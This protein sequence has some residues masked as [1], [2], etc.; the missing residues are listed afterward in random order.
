MTHS[1]KNLI[2]LS[3]FLGTFVWAQTPAPQQPEDPN[4]A[5]RTGEG[6][7]RIAASLDSPSRAESMRFRDLVA[8][9]KLKPGDSVADIGTGT[10]LLVP[11][12]SQAVGAA[13]RVYA[14]DIFADFLE[15]VR[16]KVSKEHLVNVTPVLGT[17][18]NPL[19]PRQLAA[20]V[21]VD[22]YHHFEHP[23][24]MLAAIGDALG[25][26]GRL[27]IVDFFKSTGPSPGHIRKDQDEVAREIEQNGFHLESSSK[28]SPRQ[29]VL[30][31]TKSRK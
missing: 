11:L 30:E 16:E 5:Y 18:T 1:S 27:V 3:F 12:L 2:V 4:A 9:L 6:R 13:G 7:E 15:K 14:E 24:E 21:I 26:A 20:A 29:Y 31:F 23:R 17:E 19:L 25:P 8:L 28:M 10:G 22:A